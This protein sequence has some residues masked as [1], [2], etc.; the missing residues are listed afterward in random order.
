MIYFNTI[1][2]LY[3]LYT[4]FFFILIYLYKF[5][6]IKNDYTNIVYKSLKYKIIK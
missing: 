2:Y 5:Y 6:N 3:I 4:I 1:I